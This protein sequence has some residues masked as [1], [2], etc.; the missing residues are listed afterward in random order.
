MKAIL[1]MGPDG[2]IF[3]FTNSAEV[4]KEAVRSCSYPIMAECAA[5]DRSEPYG[6][7]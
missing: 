6:M 5:R 4:A 2:I 7:D 3:P 1:D